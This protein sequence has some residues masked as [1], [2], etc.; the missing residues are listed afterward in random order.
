MKK[1]AKIHQL[2]TDK[3]SQIAICKLGERSGLFYGNEPSIEDDLQNQHLYFTTDDVIKEGDWYILKRNGF[4]LTIE[5]AMNEFEIG[6]LLGDEEKI[7]A[8]TDHELNLPQ[9]S[10]EFIEEY[11]RKGGIDEVDVEYERRTSLGE[12]KHVLLPSEWGSKGENPTRPKI[13]KDNK[14]IIHSVQKN[15]FSRDEVKLLVMWL[16]NDT[17]KLDQDVTSILSEYENLK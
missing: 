15:V 7:I 8:T 5:I 10:K 4:P 14:I 1:R 9:P 2:T 17:N 12:W 6:N 16:K 3:P 11:C 13:T